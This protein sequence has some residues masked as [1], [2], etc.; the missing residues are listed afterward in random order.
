VHIKI[1]LTAAGTDDAVAAT[2][3]RTFPRPRIFQTPIHYVQQIDLNRCKSGLHLQQLTDGEVA[4]VRDHLP[5]K[6]CLEVPFTGVV[7]LIKVAGM[8]LTVIVRSAA[9]LWLKRANPDPT[10]AL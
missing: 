9:A 8:V 7:D 6:Y 4:S 5:A 2:G 10:G 1:R 3:F